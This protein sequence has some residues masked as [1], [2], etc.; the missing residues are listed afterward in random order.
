MTD[1]LTQAEEA[2]HAA[3]VAMGVALRKLKA[4][5]IFSPEALAFVFEIEDD[6]LSAGQ[7][8]LEKRAEVMGGR[9]SVVPQTLGAERAA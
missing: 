6:P 8:L 4:A 9:L 2:C 5:G 1:K 7:F 3:R